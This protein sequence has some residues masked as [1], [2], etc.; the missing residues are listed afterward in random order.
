[1]KRSVLAA[2]MYAD[3][4]SGDRFPGGEEKIVH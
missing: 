3:W 4:L 2:K 1:M